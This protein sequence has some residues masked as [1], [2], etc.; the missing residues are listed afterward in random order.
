[1]PTINDPS[2]ALLN[3]PFAGASGNPFQAPNEFAQNLARS[4]EQREFLAIL[5]GSNQQRSA[6]AQYFANQ[7]QQTEFVK[8]LDKLQSAAGAS[9]ALDIAGGITGLQSNAFS[10]AQD[11]LA[12]ITQQ[13]EAQQALSQAELLGVQSGFI[14]QQSPTQTEFTGFTSSGRETPLDVKKS[15]AAASVPI[16]TGPVGANVDVRARAT[17]GDVALLR[18][19]IDNVPREGRV[20]QTPVRDRS[21]A[22]TTIPATDAQESK[23]QAIITSLQRLNKGTKT[24]SW[25]VR[26]DDKVAI[27]IETDVATGESIVS[28]R[29]DVDGSVVPK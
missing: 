2:I 15:V 17:P 27:I 4:R 12:I 20:A 24:Y 21:G 28:N 29:F 6:L 26:A 14:K 16:V 13:G 22:A 18:A 3:I 1:M 10:R 8:N 7:E 25:F 19:R 5:A 9:G 11:P 23:V